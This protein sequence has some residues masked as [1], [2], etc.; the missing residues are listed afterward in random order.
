MSDTM[1][2]A[3]YLGSIEH[4]VYKR[5]ESE[6]MAPL[7]AF[8][9]LAGEKPWLAFVQ[10]RLH[11][12]HAKDA[13]PQD[14]SAEAALEDT[15]QPG[16]FYAFQI[17][18]AALDADLS[19]AQ[20]TWQAPSR[21]GENITCQPIHCFNLGGIG[22]T[23]Q[24]F[25]KRVD[26]PKGRVQALWCGIAVDKA[27]SGVYT[28]EAVVA[29]DGQQPQH[30][31]I[32]LHVAGDA[33]ADMGDDE[34]WRH[35]RLRWLD[36]TIAQDDLPTAP[37]PPLKVEGKRIAC[38]GRTVALGDDGLPEAI[39]SYFEGS[40]TFL[41][42]QSR[43]ILAG[44]VEFAVDG[45]S[46]GDAAF[47]HAEQGAG[48]VQW[49]SQRRDEAAGLC[50][51]VEGSM[52][53]DG[54]MC[55]RI[56]LEADRH[57]EVQDIRLDL[58]IAREAARYAMGLGVKGGR[59]PETIDWQWDA[60]LNQD[61]LWLGDVNAGLMLRLMGEDYFKPYMLIYFIREGIDV[62]ACWDNGG[63]GGVRVREENGCVRLTAYTG[64]RAIE[65]GQPLVFLFDLMPT[66]VKIIDRHEHYGE[67]Y[68]H[69]P[70]K[71]GGLAEVAKTTANV[72]N[73]HHANRFNPFINAPF[74]EAARFRGLVEEVHAAGLKVKLYDTVKE[75]SVRTPEFFAMHSLNGELMPGK[76]DPGLSFQGHV[77]YADEWFARMLGDEG[78][79][80]AW[81]Q[82]VTNGPYDNEMEASLMAAPRS[83]FNNYFLEG[84]RW[85]LEKTGMDGLYFDDVA[86]DRT[87]MKRVRKVLDAHHNGCS[88]DLHSWN[89]FKNNNVDDARL[90]GWGN[91]M[92]LYIDNFAFIDRLWFGEGFDYDEDADFWLIEMS[93]IPFGMMGE[94]LQN[95]GNIFRG[96]L[97]GMT[98][99]LPNENDPS[100]MWRFWDEFG[101]EDA[102]LY[103][104]WNPA[105]PVATGHDDVK[106]SVFR[107]ADRILIA[108]AS[109]ADAPATIDLKADWKAMGVCPDTAEM[110]HIEGFQAQEK[111]DVS[112]LALQPGRGV[113]ITVKP[114]E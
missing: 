32:T 70:P 18:V 58:P 64:A 107:R 35:S 4:E 104:F 12:L 17:G 39:E 60:T 111:V 67:R 2:R 75:I 23:G 43:P 96:M 100:G 91:S 38:L 51:K 19:H 29:F 57:A 10:D 92:N 21:D 45:A 102:V 88:I 47:A 73:I 37:Y 90:A 30:I 31:G 36:S 80:T 22:E 84:V 106:A 56:T 97:F 113:L 95:G 68:Y 98:C 54:L 66:P 94:M 13:L 9:S 82:R 3:G 41:S 48:K 61:T 50:A 24:P 44:N 16:E 77:D 65:P 79:I 69:A 34:P 52:E 93:G 110:P 112:S 86:F 62:P 53:F 72:I 7:S 26:V 20:I 101:I 59:R 108:V 99:R 27:A 109:W 105:C 28:G 25:C 11:P 83:R 78:Y 49:Q 8:A 15:V 1:T 42:T 5:A 89:Y 55:Y 76:G 14:F 63:K 87:T 46:F 74:F 81:R 6:A 40:N 71:D 85:L 103:G 114:H 33:I